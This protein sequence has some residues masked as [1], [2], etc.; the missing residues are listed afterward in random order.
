MTTRI[1]ATNPKS[2]RLPL[3]IGL[4][5]AAGI[6][7]GE[8]CIH[9]ARQSHSTSRRGYIYRL[10]LSISQNH[11]GTL[12]DFQSLVGLQGRVYQVNRTRSQ[13]RDSYQLNYDGESALDVIKR[14]TPFLNRKS[15][16][17]KL[18]VFITPRVI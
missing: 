18:A 17:A 12:F 9:I 14:L 1:Q 16:E 4:A 3:Q 2:A 10:R 11:L 13:N 7:D 6:V 15:E 8:G 5:Y